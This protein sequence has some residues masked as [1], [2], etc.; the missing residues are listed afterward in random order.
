ML[1]VIYRTF[2][3]SYII[4]LF[5][6]VIRYTYTVFC[7]SYSAF[8]IRYSSALFS[9]H[10]RNS[11]FICGISLFVFGIRNSFLMRYSLFISVI[12]IFFSNNTCLCCNESN[13]I[14]RPVCNKKI[15]SKRNEIT[16]LTLFRQLRHNC[17]MYSSRR[18]NQS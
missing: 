11:L 6:F 16:S 7:Y 3:I 17:I 4:S 9:I 2:V 18:C 8:V 5:I 10:I 14:T 12:Q 15:N 13:A 1:F